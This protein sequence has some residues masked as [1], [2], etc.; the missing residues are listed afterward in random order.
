M[1]T[2]RDETDTDWPA[3]ADPINT[4]LM[5]VIEYVFA[6]TA[7]DSPERKAAM[8]ELLALPARIRAAL[9]PRPRLN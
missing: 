2:E 6:V 3:E 7:P 9:R 8:N 5:P 1:V 4:M